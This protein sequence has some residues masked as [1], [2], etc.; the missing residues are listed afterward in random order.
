MED[1]KSK[2]APILSKH[3]QTAWE[4]GE[5]MKALRPRIEELDRACA[6]IRQNLYGLR[7]LLNKE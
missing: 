3:N 6:E 1:S 4:L 2:G 5:Y 7:K